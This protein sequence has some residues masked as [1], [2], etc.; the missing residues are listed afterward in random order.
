MYNFVLLLILKVWIDYVFCVGCIFSYIE[1]GLVGLVKGKKVVIIFL[2][3]G[4]Y[5]EGLMEVLDFQGKYFKSVLGFIGIID[6]ELVVVE[7]VLMGEEVVKVVVVGVE[8]KIN[9]IV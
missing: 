1:I 7:G 6:V 9:V 8:V 2:C 3:G 5:F 4:K